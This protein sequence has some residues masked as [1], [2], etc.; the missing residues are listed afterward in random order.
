[1]IFL[2]TILSIIIIIFFI[3]PFSRTKPVISIIILILLYSNF[4]QF[5]LTNDDLINIKLPGGIGT[6]VFMDIIFIII[7][8]KMFTSRVKVEYKL[9]KPV[10]LLF[11]IYLLY[12]IWAIF[13]SDVKFSNIVYFFRYSYP[14]LFYFFIIFYIKKSDEFLKLLRV[15]TYLFLIIL[16]IHLVEFFRGEVFNMIGYRE[17]GLRLF[18]EKTVYVGI[19]NLEVPYIWNRDQVFAIVMIFLS[20]GFVLIKKRNL[21]PLPSIIIVFGGVISF[22]IAYSR[23]WYFVLTMGIFLSIIFNY[24]RLGIITKNIIFFSPV[25]LLVVL[26]A[27]NFISVELS[28][29]VATFDSAVHGLESNVNAREYIINSQLNYFF[30]NIFLGAGITNKTLSILS[31]NDVGITNFLMMWGLFGFIVPVYFLIYFWKKFL[32]EWKYC[33]PTFVIIVR[34][35]AALLTIG[36]LSFLFSFSSYLNSLFIPLIFSLTELFYN[37]QDRIFTIGKSPFQK[38]YLL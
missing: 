25:V 30:K 31:I 23:L 29:R 10:I 37:F 36:F 13:S 34:S 9:K 38:R 11:T 21:L 2:T 7:L 15:M 17:T 4:L 18:Y 28:N 27:A 26:L 32:Y 33:N 19:G 20:F 12:C 22:F 16:S 24:K 3:S 8:I 1:M 5:F 6:I 14:F 35:F